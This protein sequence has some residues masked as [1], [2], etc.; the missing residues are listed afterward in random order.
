MIFNMYWLDELSEN[1]IS[2]ATDLDAREIKEIIQRIT[3]NIVSEL[4]G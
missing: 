2:M 4:K 1:E 3:E